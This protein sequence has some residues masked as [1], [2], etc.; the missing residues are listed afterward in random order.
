M[1]APIVAAGIGAAGALGGAAL[2]SRGQ[3]R[4]IQAQSASDADALAFA[5]EQA[6]KEEA[7]YAD[8]QARLDQAWAE[9]QARLAP[10]RAAGLSILGNYLPGAVNAQPPSRPE[11]WTPGMSAQDGGVAAPSDS[12]GF[13]NIQRRT[14]T[15]RDTI[16]QMMQRRA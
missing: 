7:R 13:G 5:R 6:A 11:G 9:E 4:A 1:P 15:T 16:S 8:E 3:N 10:Y 2:S 12:T 14:P